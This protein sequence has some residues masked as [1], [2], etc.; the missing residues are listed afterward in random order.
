M[1]LRRRGLIL[2]AMI[3]VMILCLVLQRPMGQI[4]FRETALGHLGIRQK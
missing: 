2:V 3:L 1:S 4:I